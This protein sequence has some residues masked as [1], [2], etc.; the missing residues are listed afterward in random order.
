[1]NPDDFLNLNFALAQS[2]IITLF[3]AVVTLYI[4]HKMVRENKTQRKKN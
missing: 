3:I 1:M 2:F 4:A